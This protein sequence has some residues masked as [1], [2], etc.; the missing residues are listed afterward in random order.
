M[1][2]SLTVEQGWEGGAKW[3]KICQISIYSCGV[4]GGGRGESAFFC[5]DA[6]TIYCTNTA[7]LLKN[8]EGSG[9]HYAVNKAINFLSI[10]EAVSVRLTNDSSYIFPLIKNRPYTDH[11]YDN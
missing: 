6:C 4:G 5:R 8:R 3:G 11:I 1:C 10:T 2:L 9:E 7:Y